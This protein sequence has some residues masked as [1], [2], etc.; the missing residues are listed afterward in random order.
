LQETIAIENIPVQFGGKFEYE[1]GGLPNLDE[2]L[3]KQL[4]WV[5]ESR[6]KLP[7]G[8]LKWIV[9]DG[10]RTAVVTGSMGGERVCVPFAVLE[11]GDDGVDTTK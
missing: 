8:P 3:R 2:G 10:Q 5:G 6:T 1:P 7:A 4:R 9:R 11:E